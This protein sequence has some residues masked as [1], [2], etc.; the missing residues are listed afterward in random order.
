MAQ[1]GNARGGTQELVFFFSLNF[2]AVYIS[3]YVCMH[4]LPLPSDPAGTRGHYAGN[5]D[6]VIRTKLSRTKHILI[7][8]GDW[9]S[10]ENKPF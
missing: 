6:G 8:Y 7:V 4:R 5:T 10:G 9:T 3:S 1:L 2:A